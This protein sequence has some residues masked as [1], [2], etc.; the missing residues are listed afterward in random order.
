[1]KPFINL[2]A[3]LGLAQGPTRVGAVV[4]SRETAAQF[5]WLPDGLSDICFVSTS[6]VRVNSR[7]ND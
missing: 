6:L 4:V 3:Y 7:L 5:L 2:R 1:M